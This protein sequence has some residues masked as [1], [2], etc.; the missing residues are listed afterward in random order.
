MPKKTPTQLAE[1]RAKRSAERTPEPFGG[2]AER[3]R[4]FVVQKHAA[5]QLHYDFRL[6]LGGVLVSWA[7]PKGPS[8]DPEEKRFAAHVEDH[9]VEYA[10]FEGVIPPGNYGAG[11][12]IVWDRGRWNP[13]EDP[14]AG[15]EKGKLLFELFGYKLGGV[16]TLV[17]TKRSPK[18]WLLIKHRDAWSGTTR[19]IPETSVLSGLTVEELR[20]PHDAEALAADLEK[21]GAAKRSVDGREVRL[22]LASVGEKAF[23]R[24]GWI[25]ELKLDGFRVLAERKGPQVHLFYRRGSDANA[26]YP[27]ITRAVQALPF[28]DLL[29]D[30]EVSVLDGE[31]RPS[32]ELLQQRAMLSRTT[33]IDRRSVEL[34][35]ALH[36]FDLLSC[37]G[38]DLRRL[39]LTVRKSFLRRILPTVGPLRYVD[40]VE[41]KGAELFAEVQTRRLEGIVAKRA[42]A[43]Y[44]S[45]RSTDWIKLRTA[46]TG[47][48]VVVGY[49]EPKSSRIGLG[50]LQLAE[51]EGS[52]LAYRGRVGT[53]F[54]DALL[55]ETRARLDP[56]RI[57]HPPCEGHEI[58]KGRENHWVRPT[59]VCEVLFK[60]R[61]SQG[62]LRQASFVRFRDDKAVDECQ[63]QS[64]AAVAS[65]DPPSDLPR[66]RA[67]SDYVHQPGQ[68][69]LAQA[70]L[71]QGRS[72]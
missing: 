16:W 36:V 65:A 23:S 13:I 30:G 22:M 39:P 14:V 49:T 34:P 26:I 31:G 50:A 42:D 10:D 45:G 43:P 4:L 55:S 47:D 66:V 51:Y 53:G 5:R 25:F 32:F 70:G 17:R 19:T 37:N 8:F 71:H 29:L 69:V 48:F 6:E 2:S 59:L 64:V 67:A 63:V 12:V 56:T 1:Y 57:A 24:A 7:V 41:Q 9:P 52:R 44:R 11:E 40:H 28:H 33:D 46:Q 62:A 54:S 15:L 61:T 38:Y 68:G 60:E 21:A 18:D 35:A 72:D 58:P 20:E 27:E 3:P